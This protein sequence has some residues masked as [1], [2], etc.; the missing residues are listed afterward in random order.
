VHVRFC[1]AGCYAGGALGV[2]VLMVGPASLTTLVAFATVY[3][4]T[5][6]AQ[7]FVTS[8][9]WADYFGRG[10]QGAIRGIAS[11][12]RYLAAAAGPVVGGVLYDVTGDY[13]LAFA[14]FAASFAAGGLVALAAR[15][16]ASAR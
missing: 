8:L 15:P 12:F 5:R 16:P 2:L 7:S 14:I 9:A 11:P 4:L 13:R 6:G 3:G 1:I 10:A